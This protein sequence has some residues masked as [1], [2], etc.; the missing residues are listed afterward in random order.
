L[1]LKSDMAFLKEFLLVAAHDLGHGLGFDDGS[2]AH[3]LSLQF[4]TGAP[5]RKLQTRLLASHQ[6]RP[7]ASLK[8]A[9]SDPLSSEI[10]LSSQAGEIDLGKRAIGRRVADIFFFR[11]TTA[12]S[13]HLPIHVQRHRVYSCG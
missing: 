5:I 4:A 13:K 2:S 7:L 12:S 9:A 8:S 10:D 1:F 11:Q 6:S 3:D